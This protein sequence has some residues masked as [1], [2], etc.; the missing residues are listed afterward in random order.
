[1][2][3]QAHM[4]VYACFSLF[5]KWRLILAEQGKNNGYTD[6]PD[7]IMNLAKAMLA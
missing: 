4:R 7:N 1:M 3:A 2:H 6:N 5:L